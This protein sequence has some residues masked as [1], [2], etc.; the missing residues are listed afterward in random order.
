V[1]ADDT[2]TPAVVEP[3]PCASIQR[4][5]VPAVDGALKYAPQPFVWPSPPAAVRLVVG[6]VALL[7][8]HANAA[9][10]TAVGAGVAIILAPPFGAT[11]EL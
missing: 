3:A 8:D 11:P 7:V 4:Y 2:S 6:I 1:I 10:V 5:Q 9:P